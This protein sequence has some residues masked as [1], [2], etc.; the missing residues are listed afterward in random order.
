MTLRPLLLLGLCLAACESPAL[1]GDQKKILGV[2]EGEDVEGTVNRLNFSK[3]GRL[4]WHFWAPGYDERFELEYRLD[5]SA[6]PTRLDVHGFNRGFLEGLTL[7]G[8]LEFRQ[9]GT[10][11][12]EFERGPSDID[13]GEALRPTR[14][15]REALV[16]HRVSP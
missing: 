6:N 14:F 7:Y 5:S 15:G 2:W 12:V 8:I 3:G 13:E 11:K 16:L 10:V 9:D 1:G 4:R